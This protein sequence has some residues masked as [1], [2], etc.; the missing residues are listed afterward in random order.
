[1][2]VGRGC[3]GVMEGRGECGG[4]EEEQVDQQKSY[5]YTQIIVSHLTSS[6]IAERRSILC[7]QRDALSSVTGS[8][9]IPDSPERT[10]RVCAL[11]HELLTQV[12]IVDAS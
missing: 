8:M 6:L 3:K 11:A 7:R 1:M 9:R 5:T 4:G 2:M 12:G 10:E